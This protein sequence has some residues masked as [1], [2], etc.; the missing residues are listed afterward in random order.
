MSEKFRQKI[1]GAGD[2]AKYGWRWQIQLP[3]TLTVLVTSDGDSAQDA[4]SAGDVAIEGALLEF[5]QR[6]RHD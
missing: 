6:F 5:C 3:V 1:V 2:G 4:D